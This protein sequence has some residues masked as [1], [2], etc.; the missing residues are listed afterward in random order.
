MNSLTVSGLPDTAW[1]LGSAP[2]ED[3][4]AHLR[5]LGMNPEIGVVRREALRA[6][7][8]SALADRWISSLPSAQGSAPPAGP[9]DRDPHAA[10]PDTRDGR[11]PHALLPETPDN[12]RV[13][14]LTEIAFELWRRWFPDLSCAEVLA[15][16][17][18]REYEPLDTLMFGNPIL[19]T[20][21]VHRAYRIINA[22]A[23]PGAPV[24]GA[25]FEE[26]WSHTWHD[27]ALWLR[28]LPQVL[29]H[30]GR[31]DEA[32]DLCGR[33]APIFDARAF[34][35]DRA[36]LLAQAGRAAEAVGQV[37]A[38]VRAWPRDPQVL[39]KSC[40][41]LWALGR[42]DEAMCL[43]EDVLETLEARRAGSPDPE[44]C[45]TIPAASDPSR[46]Q[47]QTGDPRCANPIPAGR[48]TTT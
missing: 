9:H 48:P 23:P 31:F 32:V 26:I 15:D 40:E 17:F 18:D 37:S 43:Y 42:A 4:V 3:L 24:N 7:S 1:N 16:E 25:L 35:A 6:G 8:P 30:R 33:L 41:T 5:A 46:A 22:C 11:A 44:D 28:C 21:A 13:S 45:V 36:L 34:L 12:D 20:E 27:L 38:N 19:V 2:T 29:G 10:P 39:R 14:L 47:Q